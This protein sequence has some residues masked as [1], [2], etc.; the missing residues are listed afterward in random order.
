M[1]K[2][3]RLILRIA[4]IFLIALLVLAFFTNPTLDDFKTEVKSQLN[5]KVQ[6]ETDNPALEYIAEIGIEFTE[7]IVE[8]MVTRKNYFVCSVYT[9]SLPDG[10]Y[11]YLGA[12]NVFFP[13]QE[14]NP[15]DIL[16]KTNFQS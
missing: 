6:E 2:L 11:L 15:L 7:N 16:S 5:T 14:K 3:L 4:F 10:D 1:F 9:V 13:L 8:K 12:F